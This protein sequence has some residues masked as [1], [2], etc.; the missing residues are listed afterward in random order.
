MIVGRRRRGSIGLQLVAVVFGLAL[1]AD[2]F[3]QQ[4]LTP[5]I[6]KVETR[7]RVPVSGGVQVGLMVPST[8]PV[9][10]DNTFIAVMLPKQDPKTGAPWV[11]LE[12]SSQDGKYSARF[13]YPLSPGTAGDVRLQVEAADLA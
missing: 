6:R 11:C 9:P 2:G 13:G 10:L 5:K 12:V 3:A 4:T 8:G 1:S 7:S